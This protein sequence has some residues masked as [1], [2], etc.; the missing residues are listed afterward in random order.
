MKDKKQIENKNDNTNDE[1]LSLKDRIIVGAFIA[2]T[3]AFEL[4]K[5]FI[6]AE[7]EDDAPLCPICGGE[8]FFED[9]GVLEC[10]EC[11]YHYYN[12]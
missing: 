4:L 2:G 11:G 1:K 7:N 12:Q 5:L 10:S 9:D 6:E 3:A 8:M